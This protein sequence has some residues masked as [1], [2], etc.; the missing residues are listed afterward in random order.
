MLCLKRL[1]ETLKRNAYTI[2]LNE[3]LKRYVYWQRMR[4]CGTAPAARHFPY[5]RHV[6]LTALQSALVLR[7]LIIQMYKIYKIYKIMN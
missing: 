4:R 2:R 6:A 3:T 1:G 5:I 7:R